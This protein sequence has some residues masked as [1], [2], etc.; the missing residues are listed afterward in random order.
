M[1]SQPGTALGHRPLA[2]GN[3][4]GLA[5]GRLPVL[6]AGRLPVLVAGRLPVLVAGRLPVPVVGRP[7]CWGSTGQP[8]SEE[9][10]RTAGLISLMVDEYCRGK[11]KSSTTIATLGRDSKNRRTPRNVYTLSHNTKQ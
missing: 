5:A 9:G 11:S 10:S 3:R 7:G 8:S 4:R 2:E 1:A 6:V